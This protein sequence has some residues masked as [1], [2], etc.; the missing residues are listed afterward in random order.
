M[1]GGVNITD[2]AKQVQ[3]RLDEKVKA[4]HAFVEQ[5]IDYQQKYLE[6]KFDSFQQTATEKMLNL[7]IRLEE[8]VAEMRGFK[9][10]LQQQLVLLDSQV[11][12]SNNVVSK[13]DTDKFIKYDFLLDDFE[14]KTASL[15]D[16]KVQ[17]TALQTERSFD[18]KDHIR[19]L[20]EVI[21]KVD[22]QEKVMVDLKTSIDQLMKADVISSAQREA[23]KEDPV[24]VFLAENFKKIITFILA[25]VGLYLLRN[26]DSVLSFLQP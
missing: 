21:K 15:E 24:R 11:K 19:D 10:V 7:S 6:Q 13:I 16:I 14:K 23:I 12:D 1:A 20:G 8:V 5:R 9:D 4:V 26:I 22:E 3:E 2:W 18:L 17:I 25:G